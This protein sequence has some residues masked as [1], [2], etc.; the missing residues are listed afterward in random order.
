MEYSIDWGNEVWASLK[1]LAIAFGIAAAVTLVIGF[2]LARFSRWGGP[3]W[4]V[5]G[6]FFTGS[7]TR[8]AA[9]GLVIAL[10]LLA[11]FG[12]RVSVLF[13]Y[14]SNDLYTALQTAA[15]GLASGGPQGADLLE[16]GKEAF[17]HSMAVFG[18]LAAIHVA[19]TMLEI[20]VGAAFEIRLRYW[21]TEGAAADWMAGRAFYRNRFVDLSAGLL[22]RRRFRRGKPDAKRK[23]ADIHPGVDNPDQRIEADITNVA[24]LGSSLFWGGG[25]S[26]TNGVLTAC[27]SIVSFTIILWDLSGPVT[28]GGVEI[29]RMMV[30]LVLVYVLVASVVAFAIGRPLIR[31][32]FW[33]ERLTANFRYALVR[34]RDGAENVALYRGERVEHAG[35]MNRFS[36]VVKNFWQ[37]VHVQ[38]AFVGWNFSVTQ[39]SVVFPYLVQ[40]PRFFD[41]QIKLGDMSQTA[42]AFGEMHDAL[43]FFRN[44]YDDFTALRASI[45]RL[46]GL[47]DADARSRTLPEIKTVDREGAVALSDIDI[48]TPSGDELIR[49]LNLSLAPGAALV[50]KGRSGSGKTT[51]LRGLAGLWPFIDGEFA[52]PPG[53]QTLFLSQMPYIPLGDLRT[54]VAYPALP[55][56]IGDE[57]IKTALEKVF[58]PHLIGRLDE[59]QDW[60]K[61]LSPGEQQRVAF[62]RILL[63]R[64]Q[65]VFM[66]EATS[67]V[68]EGLE[69]ALYSLIRTELPETILVSVSHR[70]TTDQHHTEVLELTGGGAWTLNPTD[71][72]PSLDKHS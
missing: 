60:V 47:A 36:A 55:D 52:R 10:T 33:R 29:P 6:G 67:A 30:W 27:A 21:L 28:L 23:P 22:R 57:E 43:S 51:L 14:F 61:V 44:A 3:L 54:A 12:V 37:I 63:T 56:D 39:L 20:Y 7:K 4:S 48:S 9:W 31:L 32:N 65:A 19:R 26:S 35:L 53:R 58:L 69:F 8:V 45:I 38:L 24:S 16:M 42:S 62:A 66:D 70:S 46:D 5:I 49:S 1:W 41:G 72:G 17:W 15:E 25:G 64:P 2:L 34:I 59:E 18:I 11:L 40:A 50:V 71:A 68:D 13:S